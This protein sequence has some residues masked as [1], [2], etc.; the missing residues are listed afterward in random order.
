MG[1]NTPHLMN[2]TGDIISEDDAINI[3]LESQ[4]HILIPWLHYQ[5]SF[6]CYIFGNFQR[7]AIQIKKAQ[8]ITSFALANVEV[9]FVIMLD[10]LIHLTPG[11]HRSIFTARRRIS[12]LRRTAKKAPHHLLFCLNFLQ[13]ELAGCLGSF[14]VAVAKYMIAA[15][16]AKESNSL[17]NLGL[18]NERFGDF[19]SRFGRLNDSQECYRQAMQAFNDVGAA[20]KVEHIL[21]RHPE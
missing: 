1:K 19:Y 11:K 10:G 17:I 16:L 14:D 21:Q 9:N 8:T 2:L 6:L 15:A 7:A 20:A 5:I 4:N 13:A 18:I 3:L 12:I